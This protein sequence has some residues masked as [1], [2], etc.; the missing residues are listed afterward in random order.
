MKKCFISKNSLHGQKRVKQLAVYH[1][2]LQKLYLDVQFAIKA[3]FFFYLCFT[4]SLI[5]LNH[6]I[7]MRV[8]DISPLLNI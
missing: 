6:L 8:N 2:L 3:L 5:V 4:D 1:A 7:V